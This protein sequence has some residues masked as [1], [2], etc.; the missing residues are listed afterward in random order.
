MSESFISI[1]PAIQGGSPC[2]NHTRLPYDCLTGVYWHHG[3][4]EVFLS[5]PES[6]KDDL[7]TALWYA[8]RYG[9]RTERKRFGEWANGNGGDH[10]WSKQYKL[11][12]M[13]PTKNGATQ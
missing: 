9:T 5:Y 1:D 7:L 6:T 2:L 8:G 3:E 10:L 12:N 11:E 13:P 4:V